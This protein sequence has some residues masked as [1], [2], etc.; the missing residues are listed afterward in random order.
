MMN[1]EVID[2]TRVSFFS[3]QNKALFA[4]AI[5]EFMY[6]IIIHVSHWLM[7]IFFLLGTCELKCAHLVRDL[8]TAE[9]KLENRA[10]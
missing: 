3:N 1:H 10:A 9:N 5:I 2:S 8:S 4:S 6:D 7:W